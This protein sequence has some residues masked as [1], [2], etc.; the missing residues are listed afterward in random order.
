MRSRPHCGG[1]ATPSLCPHRQEDVLGYDADTQQEAQPKRDDR[2]EKNG[3]REG[4]RQ[5]RR[6]GEM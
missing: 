3:G 1:R 5:R 4:R 2:R 6:Q